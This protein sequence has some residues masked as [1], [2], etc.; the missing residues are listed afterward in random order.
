[1]G[2]RLRLSRAPM[3]VVLARSDSK[4]RAQLEYAAQE[5]D[6]WES[7]IEERDGYLRAVFANKRFKET[8]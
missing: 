3:V 8:S 4:I 2:L 7:S 6:R 5:A 1:M